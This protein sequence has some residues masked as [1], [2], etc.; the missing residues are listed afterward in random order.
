[1]NRMDSEK[2]Q[3]AREREKSGRVDRVMKDWM[4][5]CSKNQFLGQLSIELKELLRRQPNPPL[6]KKTDDGLSHSQVDDKLLQL[7][8]PSMEPTQVW[9]WNLQCS[10][11]YYIKCIN[12]ILYVSARLR[13]VAVSFIYMHDHKH[14]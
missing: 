10:F 7:P 5:D 12:I 1:M 13:H 8:N 14:L 6:P 11:T 9:C 4:T 2:L 3:Q